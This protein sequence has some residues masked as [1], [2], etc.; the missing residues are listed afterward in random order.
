MIH[1]SVEPEEI[2]LLGFEVG[3]PQVFIL[4][5]QCLQKQTIVEINTVLSGKE[6]DQLSR[7][8]AVLKKGGRG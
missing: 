4:I 7:A 3:N 8:F 6:D 5:T 2:Q 1:I